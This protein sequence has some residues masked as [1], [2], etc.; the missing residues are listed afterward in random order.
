MMSPKTSRVAAALLDDPLRSTEVVQ[1]VEATLPVSDPADALHPA[2][3]PLSSSDPR[4]PLKASELPAKGYKAGG[5]PRA[6]EATASPT[7]RLT[8]Y[9]T[10]VQ[11][12]TLRHE[13]LKRQNQGRRADVS[14]LIREA[15]G[16]T[17][18]RSQ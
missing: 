11:I 15:L 16:K 5:R 9:L 18:P 7:V 8:V 4:P 6:E 14:S 3:L 10:Q 13:V 2:S 17:F 12:M 1:A